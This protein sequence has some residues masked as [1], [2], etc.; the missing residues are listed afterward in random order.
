MAE[1]TPPR[2][3]RL[4]ATGSADIDRIWRY[5]KDNLDEHLV[6]RSLESIQACIGPESREE[7][8]SASAFVHVECEKGRIW[9]VLGAFDGDGDLPETELGGGIVTLNGFRLMRLMGRLQA[10][11]IHTARPE[12][13]VSAT[14]F[15]KHRAM[16]ERLR[17]LG[18]ERWDDAP[19]QSMRA[20]EQMANGNSFDRYMAP[21][22]AL[23]AMTTMLRKYETVLVNTNAGTG[24]KLTIH[25][26]HPLFASLRLMSSS[27]E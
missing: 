12:A 22:T 2:V 26:D 21:K 17:A 8:Q 27:R 4:K 19:E 16:I 23:E 24:A 11:R 5:Y 18:F 25:L 7:D 3:V 14:V 6:S 1:T 13:I 20:R 10:A 9:G 15:T